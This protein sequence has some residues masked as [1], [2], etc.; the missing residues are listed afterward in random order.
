M[1]QYVLPILSGAISL[2][3][4]IWVNME[5]EDARP[6]DL[7]CLRNKLAQLKILAQEIEIVRNELRLTIAALKEMIETK[8][9]E[10]SVS[11]N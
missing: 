9:Q 2:L 6:N 10:S 11:R 5:Q 3:T 1:V 8:L 4:D 7:K